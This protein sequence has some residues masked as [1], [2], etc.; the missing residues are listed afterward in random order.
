MFRTLVKKQ[1]Y[2]IFKGW[3]FNAK[4]NKKRSRVGTV[5]IILLFVL[6]IAGIVGGGVTIMLTALCPPLISVD[7]GWLY[8]AFAGGIAVL[9]GAFGSIF[10]TY[11]GLYLAK[12][13]DLLFSLPIP[14][15]VIVTSRL[16]TVYILGLIYSGIVTLPAAV[17]YLV[18]APITLLSLLGGILF[19]IN[20]SLLVLILS[21]GLGYV[22]ARI[23]VKLKNKSYLSV[24]IALLAIAAYY[25]VYFKATEWISAG[26][27]TVLAVGSSF[28]DQAYFIYLL[29][30]FAEGNVLGI[31]C[32]TSLHV[33]L[34][35]L[36]IYVIS[37]SF[38]KVSIR[39]ST[40]TQARQKTVNVK[41]KSVFFTLVDKERVRFTS[42]ATYM[43]NAGLGLL[44]FIVLAVA[45]FVIKG[46]LEGLNS[47]FFSANYS[48]ITCAAAIMVICFCV[49]GVFIVVP[50]VS[51]EGK[52]I[53]Q[54]KCT[55]IDPALVLK[56]K[57]AF[58]IM[59][60]APCVFISS[61][62]C[63]IA[64]ADN[65]LQVLSVVLLPQAYLLLFTFL[66]L[67][68]GVKMA[69]LNWTN[70]IVP[71]KQ[72]LNVLIAL[73]GGWI[74]DAV[75]ALPFVLMIGVVPVE[76]YALILFA[77]ISAATVLLWRALKENMVK[78]FERL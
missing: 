10:S 32:S 22:V 68:L 6:L 35:A 4:N 66:G 67:F 78:A 48:S 63:A 20:V 3:F 41:Q 75:I 1:L 61:V 72:N 27:Q 23:S 37:R 34:T 58:Q 65:V 64:F 60:T 44:F 69:N 16:F 40:V 39:S 38:I 76:Y 55:P 36:T 8:Y 77:V 2:E 7:C 5:A 11:S 13:N 31:I 12:D 42:S 14:A 56:A 49:S 18:F 46:K 74:L 62:C 47:E 54:L 28:K 50:S 21:C 9:I 26:L 30:C 45:A 53:W 70:E 57:A 71:I 73:F 33:G 59:V 15:R 19:I 29:G 43:L 25:F 24:I 17:V 52:A 51:L